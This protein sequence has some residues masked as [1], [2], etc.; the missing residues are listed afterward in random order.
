MERKWTE[1][2][3]HVQDDAFVEL[4]D[5][6]IY[7]NAN[8]FAALPSCVTHYKTYGA[9]GMSKNY[10]LSFDPKLGNGVLQFA[11]YYVHVLIEQQC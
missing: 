9:R 6:K 10:H 3:Y 5:C 2:K 11:V 1:R 7:C 4:K 8:Q